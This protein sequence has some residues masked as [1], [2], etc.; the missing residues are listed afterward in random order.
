MVGT[1]LGGYG[2]DGTDGCGVPAMLPRSLRCVGRR[3]QTERRK[4]PAHSGRD[5]GLA[6]LALTATSR[7]LVS[8]DGRVPAW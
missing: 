1:G 2:R 6:E 3:S 8:V 4:K 7:Y 5:D